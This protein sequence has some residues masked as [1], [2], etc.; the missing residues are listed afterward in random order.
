[1][2]YITDRYE[3]AHAMNFGKY[4]VMRID[5]ETCK[6]GYDDYFEGDLVKV[7]APTKSH[8]DM[9]CTGKLC[10]TEGEFSV[11]TD[12]ICLHS[13]F[14]YNDIIEMLSKAQAPVL[15]SGDTVVVIEDYPKQKKCNVRFMKVGERVNAHVYPC[16][17]LKDVPDNFD[18]SVPRKW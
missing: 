14:G 5:L 10:Y 18:T 8:P 16:V 11:M 12:T 4:P 2:K 3:I 1:M 15:H 6:D 17:E 7:M 13:W 9:Y